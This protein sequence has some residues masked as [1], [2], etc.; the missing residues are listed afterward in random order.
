MPELLDSLDSLYFLDLRFIPLSSSRNVLFLACKYHLTLF[1]T[2]THASLPCPSHVE[3]SH[4]SLPVL[5]APASHSAYSGSVCHV[6]SLLVFSAV[7]SWLQ[8]LLT[9]CLVSVLFRF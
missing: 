4:S 1:V 3:P 9:V 8:K 6:P 7:S 5:M 2:S